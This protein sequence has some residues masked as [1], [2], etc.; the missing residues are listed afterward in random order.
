L[1][2]TPELNEQACD[3]SVY[4]SL[5]IRGTGHASEEEKNKRANE[6]LYNLPELG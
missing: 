3:Q 1:L 2:S 6:K 5:S 4:D